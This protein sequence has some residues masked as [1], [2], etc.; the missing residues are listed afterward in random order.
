MFLKLDVLFC[1][2]ANGQ[3]ADEAPGRGWY[4]FRNLCMAAEVTNALFKRQ[5]FTDTF[6][7]FV[8]KKNVAGLVSVAYIH[9]H[10]NS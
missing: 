3:M 2:S 5:P 7:E 4:W 8:G 1:N 10:L 9:Y 6:S